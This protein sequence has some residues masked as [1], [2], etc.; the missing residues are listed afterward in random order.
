M[1]GHAVAKRTKLSWIMSGV[2][3]FPL[4]FTES[5]YMLIAYGIA[6]FSLYLFST[7]NFKY[8]IKSHILLFMGTISYFFYLSHIRI[9]YP[10][11]VYSGISSILGWIILTILIS[12]ILYRIYDA[13][14]LFGNH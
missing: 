9:G 12:Y 3:F 14:N 13:K 2:L 6:V 4:L 1:L 10:I 7:I 8:E 11:L 5:I